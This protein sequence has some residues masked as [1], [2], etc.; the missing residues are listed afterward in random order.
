MAGPVRKRGTSL[1][2]G[3]GTGL[4]A[5]AAQLGQRGFDLFQLGLQRATHASLVEELRLGAGFSLLATGYYQR[6]A[7]VT[8]LPPLGPQLCAPPPSPKLSGYTAEILRVV[9]GSSMG[10]ELLLRRTG[11]RVAGWIAYT[12]SRAE[13]QQALADIAKA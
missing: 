12:L 9:D 2:T 10:L 3:L 11:E 8:D 13:L 6:F 4:G 7:N 1:G 5:A